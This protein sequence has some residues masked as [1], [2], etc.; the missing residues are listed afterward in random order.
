MSTAEA[1][2]FNPLWSGKLPIDEQDL[3]NQG[4][5]YNATLAM[6]QKLI[7]PMAKNM[8]REMVDGL[9]AKGFLTL[10]TPLYELILQ[11]AGGYLMDQGAVRHILSGRI[12]VKSGVEIQSF[13]KNGV[14]LTDGTR[15]TADAVVLASVTL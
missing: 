5:P 2:V 14:V 10:D 11:R 13:E 15:L 7:H 4:I 1:I 3:L 8:D 9:H 6:M 12:D